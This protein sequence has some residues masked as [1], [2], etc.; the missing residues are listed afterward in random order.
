WARPRLAFATTSDSMTFA[1]VTPVVYERRGV[2]LQPHPTLG[3]GV[4]AVSLD[5]AIQAIQNSDFVVVPLTSEG[6]QIYPFVRCMDEYRPRL[7]ELCHRAFFEK[8]R[9]RLPNTTV[10]LY[11]R[12]P[13]HV[14]G[15]TRDGRITKAG[16]TVCAD[17]AVLKRWPHLRMVGK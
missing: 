3:G 5:E 12:P 13:F 17:C 8:G 16:L 1:L 6:P 10:V 7:L 2:V 4:N 11:M 15:T 14:Q 9:F